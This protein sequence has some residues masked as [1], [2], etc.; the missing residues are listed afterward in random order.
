MK[1]LLYLHIR[2]AADVV[3]VILLIAALL[4]GLE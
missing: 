2:R 4:F 1:K 3:G